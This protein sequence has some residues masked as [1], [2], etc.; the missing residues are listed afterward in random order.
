MRIR[1]LKNGT[2]G[3]NPVKGAGEILVGKCLTPEQKLE[4]SFPVFFLFP[5]I[6]RINMLSSFP[7]TLHLCCY[8]V[9]KSCYFENISLSNINYIGIVMLKL[10]PV[11]LKVSKIACM[12]Q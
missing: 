2:H 7:I 9:R 10:L 12:P 4:K 6:T 8:V 1:Y 3:W 11:A 5:Q